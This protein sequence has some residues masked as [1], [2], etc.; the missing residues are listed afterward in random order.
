MLKVNTYPDVGFKLFFFQPSLGKCIPIDE[1]VFQAGWF[2]HQVVMHGDV[3]LSATSIRWSLM[4]S[5]SGCAISGLCGILYD[6]VPMGE[7]KALL[8]DY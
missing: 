2:N 1:H 3:I 7:N 5:S 8:R 4:A 6:R